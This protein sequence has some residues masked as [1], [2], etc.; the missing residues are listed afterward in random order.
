[1]RE[2]L[3]SLSW[4]PRWV[5]SSCLLQW[6]DVHHFIITLSVPPKVQFLSDQL[7]WFTGDPFSFSVKKKKKDR[8]RN[9]IESE[10]S[11]KETNERKMRETVNERQREK[12]RK[13]VERKRERGERDVR[14]GKRQF[15]S[16]TYS[17]IDR[18][19]RSQVLFGHDEKTNA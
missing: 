11:G 12:K 19:K 1:M 16:L 14:K 15:E 17:L 3:Y 6:T 18:R 2:C 13:T 5:T 9:I 10:I 7:H 8:D 4:Q